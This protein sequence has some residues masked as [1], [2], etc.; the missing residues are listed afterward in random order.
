MRSTFSGTIGR[1]AAI[2]AMTLAAAL[3]GRAAATDLGSAQLFIAGTRLTVEPARQTVPYDTPTVVRTR[4]EGYDTSRGT[5]PPTFK[6][7]ADFTGPEV[8]GVLRLE[9]TPNEPFRIPRLSLKGEYQLDNIRLV[10][11][12]NLLAFAEPRSAT[13]LVTQILITRV[14][15]RPLT[16]DEIRAKGIVVD[17]DN[18]RPFDFTFGFGIVGG[19]VVEVSEGGVEEEETGDGLR[20]LPLH[21]V[22]YFPSD[23]PHITRPKPFIPPKVVMTR[24]EPGGCSE[25]CFGIQVPPIPAAIVLPFDNLVL[26]QFFSVMLLAQNGA[27]AGDRLVLRDLT[28]K[29]DLPLALRPASTEPPTPLGVP[30]PVR[31]PGPDGTLGTADDDGRLGGQETGQAEFLVEGLREGNHLVDIDLEGTLEGLA[32]GGIQ[33]LTGHAQGAVLVRNPTFGVVLQHPR[34]VLANQEYTIRLSLTNTSA[35]ALANLVRVTLPIAG[36]AGAEVIGPNQF[37]IDTLRPGE[38]RV[39]KFLLRARVE[40]RVGATAIRA[41]A[42]VSAAIQLTATVGRIAADVAP[43]AIALPTE[44]EALPPLLL[45]EL[46]AFLG[47]AFTVA[48]TPR[49]ALGANLP[50]VSRSAVEVRTSELG[51]TGRYHTLGEDLFDS[52]ALLA[53]EWTGARDELFDWDELRR[54]TSEGARLGFA[55]STVV[56]EEAAA[57]SP[58]AAFARFFDNLADLAPTAGVLGVGPG[59]EIEVADRVTGA[60]L[61]GTGV[62]NVRARDLPFADLYGL[63]SGQMAFLARPGAEGYQVRLR[64]RQGGSPDL[65]LILPL[66]GGGLGRVSFPNLPAMTPNGLLVADFAPGADTVTALVDTD[67]DGVV[68]EQIPA[69]VEPLAIRPFQAVA[70]F[71]NGHVDQSAHVVDVL[72][73]REV[74]LSSLLPLASDRFRLPGRQSNG[75]LTAGEVSR[76][77]EGGSTRIVR[78]VFDN[79]ISPFVEQDLIV[80]DVASLGGATLVDQPVPLHSNIS[81]PGIRVTGRVIGPDGTA[82]PRAF[83]ELFEFELSDLPL[84][85]SCVRRRTAAVQADDNGDYTFDYVR[86]TACDGEFHL[87]AVDAEGTVEG[88]V[89]D[90]V[91]TSDATVRID[92]VMLGRGVLRGKV[93]YPDGTIPQGL[94]TAYQQVLGIGKSAR[95]DVNGNY[96]LRGMPVGTISMV[97]RD[98]EGEFVAATLEMPQAGAVVT[99]DLVIVPAPE[100]VLGGLRGRVLEPDGVTPIPNT[101]VTVGSAQWN[102]STFTRTDSLGRYEFDALP[103]GGVFLT[104]N[105]Y[106]AGRRG[107]QAFATVVS[108]SV[109]EADIL[110]TNESGAVEG[111][112][113]LEDFLGR[114]PVAGAIVWADGTP[115]NTLTDDTGYYRLDGV[116]T[117]SYRIGAI[118]PGLTLRQLEPVDLTADGQTVTRDITFRPLLNNAAIAGEFLDENGQPLVGT[119]HI[120]SSNSTTWFGETQ[121]GSDGRFLIEG[122][123]PGIYDVHGVKGSIGASHLVEIR[124]SGQTAFVTLRVQRGTVRGHVRARQE[125]GSFLGVRSFVQYSV[126]TVKF[127]LVRNWDTAVLE[128]DD[129]GHFEI[130]DQLI[131]P[132]F[133]NVQNPFYGNKAAGGEWLFHGDTQ[134]HTFDFEPNGTIRGVVR[135]YDGT[136]VEGARVNLGHPNFTSFEVTTDDTGAFRFELVPPANERFPIDAFYEHDGVFRRARIWVEF[137]RRGQILETE[138]TLTR[139]GMVQGWVENQFGQ[140]MPGLTVTLAEGNYPSRRLQDISDSNGS[141]SF[142]NIFAGPVSV[143]V[144]SVDRGTGGKA[145]G[146]LLNEAQE[147]IFRIPVKVN[148]GSIRGRVLSPVDGSLVGSVQ[149]ELRRGSSRESQVAT[150]EGEF[151]FVALD[152]G[153]YELVAFDPRTGRAGRIARID[154]APAEAADRT[155]V[156]EARGSVAGTLTDPDTGRGVPAGTIRLDTSGIQYFRTFASTDPN[157]AFEFGGIPQGTFSLYATEYLGRRTASASGE[158]AREDEVVVKN[159][160]WQATTTVI[161]RVLQGDGITPWDR[162][163]TVGLFES[164]GY[165]TSGRLIAGSAANPFQLSG[166][167]Q[168]RS[169]AVEAT[170]QG[171]AHRGRTT[172]IAT[173]GVAT[174]TADVRMVGLATVSVRVD[175]SFGN[176]LPGATVSLS[177]DGFYGQR[178]LQATTDATGTARFFDLGEGPISVTARH[179]FSTLRGSASAQVRF[180]GQTLPIVLT[181]EDTGRV[182]GAVLRSDG[183]S[184]AIQALVSLRMTTGG[185][186]ELLAFTAP[187][188]TFDFPAV[189]LGSFTVDFIEN[190]APGLNKRTASITANGQEL[191]L[192]AVV[193]DDA[194]PA[195]VSVTP[196]PGT[197]AQPITTPIVIRFSEPIDIA[198]NAAGA[199][200]L[201]RTGFTGAVS[202]SKA[203]SEGNTVLTLTPTSIL[204]S[205]ASYQVRVPNTI[206]DLAVRRLEASYQSSFTTADGHPPTVTFLYPA[207][208][209]VDV[210]VDVQLRTMFSESIDATDLATSFQL[211]KVSNGEPVPFQVRLEANGREVLIDQIDPLIPQIQYRLTVQGVRD[212]AGNLMV[213]SKETVFR[214]IDVSP[215]ILQ[216]IYP[217]PDVVVLSGEELYVSSYAEDNFQLTLVKFTLGG[218][219]RSFPLTNNGSRRVYLAHTFAAPFVEEPQ[220][221]PL[222]YEAQDAAGNSTVVES[223]VHV[224][225]VFDPNRP[226]LD[227]L[228][229]GE[230]I[231]LAPSTGIDLS[232]EVTDDQG[233]ERVELFLG[234]DPNPLVTRTVPPP[235]LVMR[236]DLPASVTPGQELPLRVVARDFAGGRAETRITVKVVTGFTF[237]TSTTVDENNFSYEGQSVIVKSGTLTLNGLHN[238]RDLVILGGAKVTHAPVTATAQK[239]VDVVAAEDVY[240]ACGGSLDVAARGQEPRSLPTASD[241]EGGS[242]GGRGG[243]YGAAQAVDDSPF[244]PRR[245]ARGNSSAA[246]GGVARLTAGGAIGIDG[247]LTAVGAAGTAGGAIRLDAPVL[248]GAGTVNADGTGAGG[249]GRIALY[250]TTLDP[251]LLARTTARGGSLSGSSA[252]PANQGAAGSIFVKRPEEAFGELIFDNGGRISAPPVQA[253]ELPGVGAGTVD[254]VVGSVVTDLDA[255]FPAGIEGL[256]VEFGGDPARLYRVLGRTATTLTLDAGTDP[257]PVAVGESYR[258]VLR[259]DRLTVRGAAHALTVDEVRTLPEGLSIA[260]GS[261]VLNTPGGAPTIDL[262]LSPATILYGEQTLRPRATASDDSGLLR[263]EV[264]ATGAGSGQSATIA[265]GAP[266]AAVEGAVT[267]AHVTTA[268]QIT[269]TARAYD[270][271]RRVTTTTATIATGPDPLPPTVVSHE[272]ADGALVTAGEPVTILAELTDNVRLTSVRF[273]F[274]GQTKSFPS[275]PVGLLEWLV[276]APAVSATT[277]FPVTLEGTD[278]YGNVGTYSFDLVVQPLA[279]SNA[280]VMSIPCPSPGAPFAAAAGIDVLV[281]AADDDAVERVEVYLDGTLIGVDTLAP[282]AVKVAPPVGTAPGTLLTARAVAYDYAGNSSEATVPLRVVSGVVITGLTTVTASDFGLDGVSVILA[283]S[284]TNTTRLTVDG[285]HSFANLYVLDGASVVHTASTST[286][287]LGKSLTLGITGELYVACGGAIDAS[288][289][290]YL[291]GRT[292][293]NVVGAASHGGRATASSGGAPS[294]GS[295][296]SPFEPGANVG[297]GVVDLTVAGPALLDGTV[298]ANGDLGTFLGT[299]TGGTVRIQAASIAGRGAIAAD[300]GTS[301][302]GTAGGRVALYADTVDADLVS[303]VTAYGKG[304]GTVYVKRAADPWGELIIDAG[305]RHPTVVTDLVPVGRGTIGSATATSLT[306]PARQFRFSTVGAHVALDGDLGSLWKIGG[307]AHLGTSLTFAAGEPPFTGTAGQSYEGVYRFDRVTVRGAGHLFLTDRLITT[308]PPV[309]AEGSTLVEGSTLDAPPQAAL[310]LKP[311]PTPLEGQVATLF[312]AGSTLTGLDRL[313]LTVVGP[314]AGTYNFEQNGELQ[315]TSS[316]S[317]V[318][319]GDAAGQT[320]SATLVVL[321]TAGRS[322]TVERSWTVEPD[323]RA[324]QVVLYR[325]YEG[326]QVQAGV[327]VEFGGTATDDVAVAS[328]VAEFGLTTQGVTG[329]FFSDQIVAPPV[330]EPTNVPLTL[331]ARDRAGNETRVSRR[332]RVLPNGDGTPPS[333]TL[334]CPRETTSVL[335]GQEL[336]IQFVDS[337]DTYVVEAFLGDGEV[338]VAQSL[339]G[340]EPLIV[341]VPADAAVGSTVAIRLRSTDFGGNTALRTIT[342]QVRDGVRIAASGNLSAGD[343]SLEGQ[344]VVVTGEGVVWTIEGP[345]TFRSLTVLNGAQVVHPEATATT[346]H[347]L[348]LAI[349]EDV[350]VACGS[351]IHADGRGYLGAPTLTDSPYTYPNVPYFQG[352]GSHGGGGGFGPEP[353]DSVFDPRQPGGGGDAYRFGSFGTTYPGGDGGGVVRLAAAGPIVVEGRITAN[354]TGNSG[355]NGG[356]G[357][358]LRLDAA[359]LSGD[360]V[361]QALGGT[362]LQLTSGTGGG[363]RI[364]IYAGSVAPNLL[365]A[366]SAAAGAKGSATTTF[367]RGSAGTIFVRRDSDVLGELIIDNRFPGQSSMASTKPTG[368]PRIAGGHL[369]ASGVDTVTDDRAFFGHDSTGAEIKLRGDPAAIWRIARYD[370]ATT[371]GL[372]VA[373]QPLVAQVGDA[374][375]GLW[376]FDRVIVR[377]QAVAQ[378]DDPVLTTEPAQVEAGSTWAPSTNAAGP[379]IDPSRFRF[380]LGLFGL[381]LIAEPGAVSDAEPPVRLQIQGDVNGSFY[382]IEAAAD[383]SFSLSINGTEGEHFTV[384]PFDSGVPSLPG[385]TL[386][387]GPLVGGFLAREIQGGDAVA[388]GDGLAAVC[389]SCFVNPE[390]QAN[391]EMAIYDLEGGTDPVSTFTLTPSFEDPRFDRCT[392]S[393]GSAFD[394]CYELGEDPIC[395]QVADTAYNSCYEGADCATAVALCT[396]ECTA[397]GDPASCVDACGAARTTCESFPPLVE[398]EIEVGEIPWTVHAMAIDDGALVIAQGPWVRVVDLRDPSRPVLRDTTQAL[399]L[400]PDVPVQWNGWPGWSLD[401]DDGVAH[402]IREGAPNSYFAIDVHDPQR[403]RVINQFD[404]SIRAASDLEV[405][406]GELHVVSNSTGSA[407]EYRLFAVGEP[408]APPILRTGSGLGASARRGNQVSL[409]D[410]VALYTLEG[411][412]TMA[413]FHRGQRSNEAPR[414]LTLDFWPRALA[415]V[416]DQLLVAEDGGNRAVLG[417]VDTSLA[418]HGLSSPTEVQLPTSTYELNVAAGSIFFGTVGYPSIL[419]RPW[420]AEAAVTAA[421]VGGSHRIGGGPGAAEG[422]ASVTASFAGTTQT[423]PVVADGSFLLLLGER[424]PGER[425]TLQAADALGRRGNKL[426]LDLPAGADGGRLEIRGLGAR[427]SVSGTRAAVAAEPAVVEGTRIVLAELGGVPTELAAIDTTGPV[428][429]VVLA[430]DAL[431]A[432]AAGLQVFDVSSPA[433]PAA[434]TTLDLFAGQPVQALAALPGGELAALSGLELKTLS[435]GSPLAPAVLTTTAV[436]ALAAPRLVVEGT[437]LWLVGEGAVYRYALTPGL[438]PALEAS[439]SFPGVRATDVETFGGTPWLAVA[440]QGLR[441]LAQAGATLTLGAVPSELHP[442]LALFRIPAPGGTERLWWAE[443]IGG[444]QT[445]LRT[446]TPVAGVTLPV[447]GHLVSRC[448]VRDAAA[449]AG[450]L[451]LLT[452]CGIERIDR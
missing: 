393:I 262:T 268:G 264:V 435:V 325:P 232:L 146:D 414:I 219:V 371:L 380:D 239:S 223:L 331:I 90:R 233:V 450:N 288:S 190:A 258:G 334:V 124:A 89:R 361:I 209:A 128:T 182:F 145:N 102:Y 227:V 272:P 157:G 340:N 423:A 114:N 216:P 203:W 202:T 229:P 426:R 211:V 87:H 403:P 41:G 191:D 285:V 407:A 402:L 78:V 36:V 92:I 113:Y 376:R 434:V 3:A 93:R 193:L 276:T 81:T 220:D 151:E 2:L 17:E 174:Q 58:N 210:P 259:L 129:Q 238:F 432:G 313:T 160:A 79:P 282:Y 333:L 33:R 176:P 415:E 348:E 381:S 341:T 177:A 172:G 132:Y 326:T 314:G 352:G 47:Q 254:A 32:T 18:F 167:V 237:S 35:N 281:E 346:V 95:L 307:H 395:Y 388:F 338:A 30:V 72:F 34:R 10:D 68:D 383:G 289:K 84:G 413:S 336:P 104:A 385:R 386:V 342:A 302:G 343:T 300:G 44:A 452:D 91:R 363:G 217:G 317:I 149:L 27:P 24:L 270:V 42:D 370:S 61:A 142:S 369:S 37:T 22:P 29:I 169:F 290:G 171:G 439:G 153:A 224:E 103:P 187:D 449:V 391:F 148:V 400:V 156:L 123:G 231:V 131:G 266:A 240:V 410:D 364:A 418:A 306:D 161:G 278:S 267:L 200:E 66:A 97:A 185:T 228:C 441:A 154:L 121:S 116:P 260:A 246:G 40:G 321:D 15:S 299:G 5:L 409:V 8:D 178:S 291:T 339:Y 4:L 51:R 372:A 208:N 65:E 436:P 207:N 152:A 255:A 447:L 244:D 448:A 451:Y 135:N 38:T 330:T 126:P 345:H 373:G 14:T 408:G 125:D 109:S 144:E 412:S 374:Y 261:S 275:N 69:A 358:T 304:A 249:G 440:N 105:P 444:A 242:H 31:E 419:L 20:G 55:F 406:D 96:E 75:G 23:I 401:I 159:L 296:F 445:V 162:A 397:V 107:G 234:D 257:L 263:V 367:H 192:G 158:I 56:A 164:P 204:E 265:A 218:Q 293:P 189:P 349:L 46:T 323:T 425:V 213:G 54:K 175:D 404:L 45:D 16:A 365:L 318:L 301:G 86:R 427:W 179:P 319:P 122:Y 280:P 226:N 73:S 256:W 235:S 150:A 134:E 59:V 214:T 147:L 399:E 143:T 7:V 222:R 71:L 80:D 139:Q 6:V 424:E 64:A 52:I 420:L 60:R 12:D 405:R 26:N 183:T 49:S 76:L 201:R 392:Q 165:N 205:L 108:D 100:L 328:F 19:E 225:P 366:T 315:N 350:F 184:P 186:R 252:I 195:I 429:D 377:G 389:S 111:H 308:E 378:I 303:R 245:A 344:D 9:T 62:D 119:I 70:A 140:R 13:V 353:F 180:D 21:R 359:S 155:L 77:G 1:T 357:G 438:A 437:T 98:D 316:V 206:K 94:V 273:L 115:Y 271:Y 322:T 118:D 351:A 368:L 101:L 417:P 305:D 446:D 327:R 197:L 329:N 127:G 431:Y 247:T 442:A 375:R 74:D 48:T 310:N 53:A 443:G 39:L 194:P 360:G 50:A 320:L 57:T 138:I 236:L 28:A 421:F 63:D 279:N 230:R 120:S 347:R 67:G 88:T 82:L 356:A 112:V 215:P 283:Q 269:V 284:G 422:A 166:L 168:G 387:L 428:G 106:S 25:N 250:V 251:G 170:E 136:V 274:N 83:V 337:D 332:V 286:G 198:G 379:V 433:T 335:P 297:G 362:S 324:P 248:G 199:V 99:R 398:S 181:L 133:L 163:A 130:A 294:Y 295:V 137:R 354:A 141:F 212:V 11:G 253:S 396:A 394:R 384:T 241:A 43:N 390:V 411:G 298:L 355:G 311:G 85:E 188:G 243:R 309:V 312:A 196:G 287:A 277:P 221:L 416:G 110:V 117:G 382:E 430:G 173:V 292:Y